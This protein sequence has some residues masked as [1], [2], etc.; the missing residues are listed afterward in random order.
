MAYADNFIPAVWSK[1]TQKEFD[2]TTT[3]ANLVNRN[4][5]GDI[6]MAGDTVN[7]RTFGNI[8]INNY[9]REQT[10]TAQA[11]TDPMS[12]LVINQQKYWSFLVD[13]LDAAQS[14]LDIIKGYTRRAGVA[15]KQ[16]IDAHLLSHYADAGTINGTSGAPAFTITSANVYQA[17]CEIVEDLVLQNVNVD[18]EDVA[19]VVPPQF[20]TK[21]LQASVITRDTEMGDKAVSRGYVGS[22]AGAK[23]YRTT[24]MSAVSGAY[25][26]MC[27]TKDFISF[28]SQ[29]SKTKAGSDANKFS[30]QVSGLFLYGSKVFTNHAD[31][32]ATTWVTF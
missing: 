7:V 20:V 6:K 15:I 3:M 4:W 30:T 31:A 22:I 2:N 21:L 17:V 29:V 13:D 10:L 18:A 24:N 12:S 19:L 5:E 11:L 27:F 32:G 28:A 25:P 9:T 16:T 1:Q 8:T 23:I 26:I 14:D